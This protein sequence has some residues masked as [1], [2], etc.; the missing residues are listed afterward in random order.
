M[1]TTVIDDVE[2]DVCPFCEMPQA[3]DNDNDRDADNALDVEL[4]WRPY[5]GTCPRPPVDPKAEVVRLRAILDDTVEQLR[6]EYANN[7]A[8]QVS[9][10]E[11]GRQWSIERAELERQLKE[12]TSAWSDGYKE[13]MSDAACIETCGNLL[14][15]IVEHCDALFIKGVLDA[16]RSE[17]ENDLCAL[18]AGA[19][20]KG[21][22]ERCTPGIE[23][24][25]DVHDVTKTM[26][27]RAGVEAALVILRAEYAR[28]R[29]DEATTVSGEAFDAVA[30]LVTW[31]SK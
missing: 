29:G 2:H 15:H 18:L 30:K 1:T 10:T 6:R 13:G 3:L 27:Y 22:C 25:P 20:S 5:S 11:Y 8:L 14:R 9:T 17:K 28:S 21:P 31:E 24:I 7:E 23:P 12:M 26:G 16:D 19:R 4:C